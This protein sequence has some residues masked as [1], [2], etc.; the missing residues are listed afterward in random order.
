MIQWKNSTIVN[1]TVPD[2]DDNKI[3]LRYIGLENLDI[4][5]LEDKRTE[6]LERLNKPDSNQLQ[7]TLEGDLRVGA[8]EIN[9][10]EQE[11]EKQKILRGIK[12]ID[13]EIKR[14]KEA[15]LTKEHR[16]EFNQKASNEN[17]SGLT[18]EQKTRIL[19]KQFAKKMRADKERE[20]Q[21][22]E[23]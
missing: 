17:N 10:K 23:R 1:F 16:D 8:N 5:Q 3:P 11:V 19:S 4:Q 14:Q 18:K 13:T 7:P 22:R 6:D 2:N 9:I 12:E 21:D 20:E 15:L